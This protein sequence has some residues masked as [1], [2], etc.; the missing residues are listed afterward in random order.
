MIAEAFLDTNV[1]LYSYSAAPE[2]ATKR[3]VAEGLILNTPFALSAQVLQE[4]IANALRKKSLGL[5]ES[6]IDTMLEL[7]GKVTVQS[8][9]Y[10]LVL[11]AVMLRRRYQLSQWDAAIIAAAVELGCRT[12]YSEDMND[13]QEYAGVRVENPFSG[14]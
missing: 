4:F 3:R 5:D 14:M 12:V 7:A 2:D 9:T 6:S 11:A 8:I 10:E 1:L 13:G